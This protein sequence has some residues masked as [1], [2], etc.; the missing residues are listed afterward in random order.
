M[1]CQQLSKAVIK[2]AQDTLVETM[3]GKT[4]KFEGVRRWT[5]KV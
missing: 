2:D 3:A 5:R 4:N 1:F